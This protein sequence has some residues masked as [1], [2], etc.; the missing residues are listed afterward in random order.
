MGSASRRCDDE[1]N[2]ACGAFVGEQIAGDQSGRQPVRF[3]L[4]NSAA[5][6]VEFARLASGAPGPA[7]TPTRQPRLVLI[8]ESRVS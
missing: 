7:R 8:A 3:P 4:A 5:S 1:A 2:A 6:I